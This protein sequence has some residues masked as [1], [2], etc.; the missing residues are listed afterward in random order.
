MLERKRTVGGR[1]A[2]EP[3]WPIKERL[4]Q[5][6]QIDPVSDCWNS[7]LRRDRKGYPQI[8]IS[9]VTHRVHR[10]AYK[11]FVADPGSLHVLH[12]CDNPRCFNP[13]HLFLGTQLDNMRDSAAKG[14]TRGG[15]RKLSEA[16]AHKV[17]MLYW[18]FGLNQAQIA[19]HYKM[20]QSVICRLVNG[21]T[22][23]RSLRK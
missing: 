10:V 12:K 4:L 7:D 21:K 2:P 13:N 9:G 16:E 23:R 11:L 20:A 15:I 5:H 14:R 8:G 22:W 17:R 18:N 3:P 6:R 19:A 1:F